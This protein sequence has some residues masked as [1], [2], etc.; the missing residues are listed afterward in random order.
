MDAL[1][2]SDKCL[3]DGASD[4]LL[5]LLIESD[6]E[7]YDQLQSSYCNFESVTWQYCLRLREKQLAAQLA[8]KYVIRHLSPE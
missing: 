7:T 4:R 3:R 5:Q 2:V 1:A 6:E 8:L